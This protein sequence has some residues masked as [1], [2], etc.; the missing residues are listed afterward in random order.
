[1]Q[2]INLLEIITPTTPYQI[3]LLILSTVCH[4]SS[5]LCLYAIGKQRNMTATKLQNNSNILRLLRYLRNLDGLGLEDVFITV[6]YTK[7]LILDITSLNL[8]IFNRIIAGFW[9][10]SSTSSMMQVSVHSMPGSN[11]IYKNRPSP[12][13]YCKYFLLIKASCYPVL[14]A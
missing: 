11:S 3:G 13:L 2:T 14:G 5:K 6:N 12:F 10:I 4:T 1:M 9:W 7:W 8:V